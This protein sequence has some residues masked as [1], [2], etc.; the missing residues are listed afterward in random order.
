[1]KTIR[2]RRLTLTLL[3]VL[4]VLSTGCGPRRTPVGD[5]F[6][7][8][9]EAQVDGA[10]ATVA[11]KVIRRA[12]VW[13]NGM[14]AAIDRDGAFAA[15]VDLAWGE[16]PILVTAEYAESG[17]MPTR[18]SHTLFV[19]RVAAGEDQVGDVYL[20][21][22]SVE[23]AQTLGHEPLVTRASGTFYVVT[24][25][26]ENKGNETIEIPALGSFALEEEKT[27]R[28]YDLSTEGGFAR[29]WD[30]EPGYLPGKEIAPKERATGW[31]VF[32]VTSAAEDAILHASGLGGTWYTRLEL[33]LISGGINE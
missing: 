4:I 9:P 19:E 14:P 30:V 16:N 32:D 33:S 8:L 21:S 10:Q 25:E 6:A 5:L 11:G 1:M 31:L 24:L 29:G 15:V 26:V 7:V 28:R 18:Q 12:R 27:G 13:V 3:P 2:A 23:K 22:V 20:R 17:Q